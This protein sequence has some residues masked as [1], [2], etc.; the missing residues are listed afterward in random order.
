[1]SDLDTLA[2]NV[3]DAARN[4][5]AIAQISA[6]QTLSLEDA[7]AIQKKMIALRIGRGER[8]VGMKMGFTSR[9]KMV[10]MGVSDMIWGRLTDRMLVEDGGRISKA[11]FVHPRAEPE[12]AYL[13]KAPLAGPVTPAQALA[14]VEAIAPAI[15]IIDSRYDN[16]KFSLEDVVADNASS[17]AFVI[18]NW[19]K[20][21]ID[22]S[23]LGM[24]LEVDGRAAQ[25]GSSA[26]ILGNPARSL[27]AASRMVAE[28]GERLEA[29]WIIMAGGA[30]EA[31]TLA[32]GTSVRNTVEKLGSVSFSVVA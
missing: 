20:P 4:A 3:D 11:K 13:L 26:A 30:T 25:V 22:C 10:Q 19:S 21:D 1:M 16:F 29:G 14:A 32:A 9:A 17:S 23:N 27:A 28:H 7:Y 24:L 6:T 8:R 2:K 12:I 5:K 15:E 18:G 31:V